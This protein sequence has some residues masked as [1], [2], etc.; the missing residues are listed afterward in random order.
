[1]SDIERR[2]SRWLSVKDLAAELGVPLKTVYNWRY[3]G[4]GPPSANFG[5]HVR[6]RREDV[7]AWIEQQYAEPR[8]AA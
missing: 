6:Y 1:M 3:R 4:Y 7:D 5:Q 8:P 2:A